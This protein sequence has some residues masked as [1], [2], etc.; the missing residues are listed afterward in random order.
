MI[1]AGAELKLLIRSRQPFLAIHGADEARAE[2]LLAS[3]AR[4]MKIPLFVWSLTLG[5]RRSGSLAELN[6]GTSL[7]QALESAKRMTAE[8]IYLFKDLQTWLQ[9]ATTQRHL[10]DLARYFDK[11]R[12]TIVMAGPDIELPPRLR[13]LCA[14]WSLPLPDDDEL[15]ALTRRVVQEFS[16]HV[17]VQVEL[18]PA[19]LERLV[20]GLRGMT[21]REAERALCRAVADDLALTS[22]DVAGIL[23]AK[24]Q[25]LRDGGVL[26][27][28]PQSTPLADVGG[29]DGLKRWLAL[30]RDAFG[31]RGRAFGLPPPK[32]ILLLGVQGCGKSLAAKAVASEWNLP[33]LRMEAGRIYDKFIGESDKNLEQAL[34]TAEHMAPCILWIDELE[35][36]FAYSASADSDGGLSRRILG[37]L[38]GWLQDRTAPVFLVATSNDVSQLP[39]ELI[40]KGRFDELFFVDLPS[41]AE[42]R[43]IF[44]VHLRRR[45]REPA[46][47]DLEALAAAAD[48]F[49]GA[50]IEQAVVAGL[51]AAFGAEDELRTEYI[52]GEVGATRPLSVIRREDIEGLRAWAAGR[53]VSAGA[54]DARA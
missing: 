44:K 9:D 22:D 25:V 49:S 35:K 38:L 51:Y 37:R 32:G 50:E 5:M 17:P 33:L 7:E 3:V 43:A 16:T 19:E 42:R 20:Q 40:R 31:V 13:P 15:R 21:A 10:L 18:S 39:P 14:T 53:T 6:R 4:D 2:I 1:D 45:G 23:E 12:R 41:L 29:L 46:G 28:V 30:R 8:A 24:R 47:F 54:T 34:K 26:E 52:L 36:A 48:G 27:Y 11:D